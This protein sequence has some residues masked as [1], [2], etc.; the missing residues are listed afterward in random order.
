MGLK[1]YYPKSEG[2]TR[3]RVWQEVKAWVGH[4][5]EVEGGWLVF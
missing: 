5:E 4:I 2:W 3:F 1:T